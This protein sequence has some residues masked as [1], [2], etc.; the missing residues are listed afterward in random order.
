MQNLLELGNYNALFAVFTALS[1]STI[2][3]LQKTWDGLAP[4]YKAIFDTLRK[5]TDHTRNYAEYRQR[6][7][8]ALPPCLPF[9]G[10]SCR[11]S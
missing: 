2:S 9:V 5:A 8:Q 1:S 11:R 6:V 3:R 7:R 10:V 4:K